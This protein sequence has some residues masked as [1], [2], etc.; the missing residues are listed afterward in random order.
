MALPLLFV[1]YILA[2]W[3]GWHSTFVLG[4]SLQPSVDSAKTSKELELQ[5]RLHGHANIMEVVTSPEGVQIFFDLELEGSGDKVCTTVRASGIP[6]KA[7]ITLNFNGVDSKDRLVSGVD[8]YPADL[9]LTL[10]AEGG[11]L[12]HGGFDY[13]EENC[14]RG[15]DLGHKWWWRGESS[16][17]VANIRPDFGDALTNAEKWHVCLGVGRRNSPHR[18]KTH[19]AI[20]LHN[21]RPGDE[22]RL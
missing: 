19:G 10:A 18:Y 11:C 7:S 20:A 13:I 12:Q 22:L 17:Y 15:G 14:I 21:V 6:D 4:N 5:R 2:E 3:A 9:F 16:I 8:H 1:A